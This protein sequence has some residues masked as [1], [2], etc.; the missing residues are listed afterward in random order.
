MIERGEEKQQFHAHAP[1]QNLAGGNGRIMLQQVPTIERR[2]RKT[3]SAVFQFRI[4]IGPMH[5]QVGPMERHAKADAENPGRHHGD[6][7]GEISVMHV[8]VFNASVL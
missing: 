5:E 6:P 3:K 7:R 8:N 4:Q 2:N 1:D